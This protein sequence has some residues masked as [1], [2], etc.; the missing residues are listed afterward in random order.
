[1]L[2]PNTD[3]EPKLNA[4]DASQ[5]LIAVDLDGTAVTATADLLAALGGGPEVIRQP[6]GH[7]VPRPAHARRPRRGDRPPG[8]HRN[9]PVFPFGGRRTAFW[10]VPSWASRPDHGIQA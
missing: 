3:L 8:G 9:L 1:M 5:A 4:L 10:W 7:P 6:P 2:R